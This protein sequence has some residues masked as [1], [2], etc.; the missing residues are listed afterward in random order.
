[1]EKGRIEAKKRRE[2]TPFDEVREEGE[3]NFITISFLLGSIINIIA[4]HHR[5]WEIVSLS[6]HV[7]DPR[8]K[9]KELEMENKE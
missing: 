8:L 5:T 2:W 6:L 4:F 3:E 1:M 9:W 7:R